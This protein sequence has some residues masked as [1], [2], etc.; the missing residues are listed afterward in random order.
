MQVEAVFAN[1]DTEKRHRAH[2]RSSAENEKSPASVNLQGFSLR[3][4]ISLSRV[5][6][7]FAL[8][9]VITHIGFLVFNSQALKK[10][11]YQKV[12][13]APSALSLVRRDLQSCTPRRFS[14]PCPWRENKPRAMTCAAPSERSDPQAYGTVKWFSERR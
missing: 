6:D 9:N 7:K 14:Q 4:T 3:L 11:P 12:T 1:V 13:L 10:T 2:E 8:R 5:F